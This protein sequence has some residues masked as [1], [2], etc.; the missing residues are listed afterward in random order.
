MSGLVTNLSMVVSFIFCVVGI[1]MSLVSISLLGVWVGIEL[2]FL[3][4]ISFMAGNSGEEVEGVIKYY[5]IQILGSC[6]NL[7]SV[8]MVMNGMWYSVSGTM[9][10]VGMF[11]KLG[12]FPFHFWV[13]PVVKNLPWASCGV[14]L[15][16]QKIVPLWVMSNYMHMKSEVNFMEVVCVLGCCFGC[17]GGLGVLNYRVL[18]GFSSIHQLGFMLMMTCFKSMSLFVY[19]SWYSMLMVVLISSLWKVNVFSL[20]DLTK[21]T[22]LNNLTIMWA[23]AMYL[24]SIAGLPPFTGCALKTLFLI[25]CWSNMMLGSSVCLMTSCVSLAFYLSMIMSMS[26]YWGKSIS[27]RVITTN[28]SAVMGVMSV[29]V[30][31]VLGPVV[32]EFSSM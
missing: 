2:N 24:F 10:L 14:I 15:I 7:M 30:N 6:F 31:L 17:F 22:V 27:S 8:L 23:L 4:V 26:V 12:A 5:I 29:L 25:T 16:L 19:F 9:L 18:L 32:F 13:A 11:I 1:L 3:A 21:D 28:S 20:L